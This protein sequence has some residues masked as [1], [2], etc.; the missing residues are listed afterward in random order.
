MSH[1]VLRMIVIASWRIVTFLMLVT[2][3]LDFEQTLGSVVGSDFGM[4]IVMVHEISLLLLWLPLNA[5]RSRQ[6]QHAA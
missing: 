3:L 6:L 4:Q 5:W 2:G 1:T